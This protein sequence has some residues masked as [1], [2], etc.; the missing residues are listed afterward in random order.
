MAS[1]TTINIKDSLDDVREERLCHVA[2][3]H[4]WRSPD[5][6]IMLVE[7]RT[8]V[9]WL[10]VVQAWRVVQEVW[11]S[12]NEAITDPIEVEM[13]MTE[14]E[15][16]LKTLGVDAD[17]LARQR[18]FS[19][20]TEGVVHRLEDVSPCVGWH[21]LRRGGI[22]T[23]RST[24]GDEDADAGGGAKTTVTSKG[25]DKDTFLRIVSN[26]LRE[27]MFSY[28]MR[29]ATVKNLIMWRRALGQPFVGS[30]FEMGRGGLVSRVACIASQLPRFVDFVIYLGS[31]RAAQTTDVARVLRCARALYVMQRHIKG[32]AW[33]P[34]GRLAA[35]LMADAEPVRCA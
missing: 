30:G 29:H 3:E 31:T 21:K 16:L 14:E 34:T 28:T 33:R 1:A 25:A 7:T 23:C 4:T 10:P 5:E 35:R 27:A 32:F 13:T 12:L 18:Y 22:I 8:A 20:A 6:W 19:H 17:R 24:F 11:A 15:A 2:V 9:S 26:D